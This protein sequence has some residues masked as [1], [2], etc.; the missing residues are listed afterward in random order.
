MHG[1]I[2][3]GTEINTKGFDNDYQK[4]E[5]E[6]Q[7][8]QN[9]LKLLIQRKDLADVQGDSDATFNVDKKIE[10]VNVEINDIQQKISELNSDTQSLGDNAERF[11][12]ELDKTKHNSEDIDKI[13]KETGKSLKK[14]TSS[15]KTTVLAVFGLRSAYMFVRNAIN[16]IAGDDKQLKSDIDYIKKAL[17]YTIEPI[18]RGIVNIVKQLLMYIG[19]IIKAWT[20]KNIFEN[21]NKSLQNT[22]KQAKELGKSLAGFDEMNIVGGGTSNNTTETITPS[23]DLSNIEEKDMP[24]LVKVIGKYGKEITAIITGIGVAVLVK[25]VSDFI[26]K[27]KEVK[28]GLSGIKALGIGIAV[29][30]IVLLIQ[31]II[32]M[33]GDPSWETFIKILTDIAIVIGGIMLVMNNWWGLLIVFIAAIVRLVVDNWDKIKEI[34]GNVGSWIYDHIIKPIA[35]FFEGLWNGIK[36]GFSA[37][38]DFVKGLWE[39]FYNTIKSILGKAKSI[40]DGFIDGVK[41]VFK[42]MANAIITVLNTL[43]DAVNLIVAPL[44]AI[45]VG[46]GFI[47]GKNWSMED[48]K[49]PN[50]PYLA[51]GGIVNN[52]GPGVMMGSYVAGEKGP[53]A[54]IPLDDNTLDRLGLSFAKHTVINAT[55]INEMNGRI[56][57]REL[58]KINAEDNFAYNG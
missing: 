46:F 49:I 50:I 5:K 54:V 15:I 21:A 27:L 57:S 19:Y 16:T 33:I 28:D 51:K 14:A 45:I 58:Q 55:I 40:I 12:N 56:I 43:I 35:D 42:G 34:L 53:E 24:A 25:K 13:I 3:I 2:I 9:E 31:D 39:G 8:K 20:G 30:G 23:F 36:E 4:L 52:P 18:V 41:S 37:A 7:D 29:T 32:D 6:L 44:R 11:S 26:K 1:K 22:N 17:A 10:K 38:I 48:I 47:I